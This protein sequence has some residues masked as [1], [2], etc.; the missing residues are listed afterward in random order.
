MIALILCI[1]FGY[2]GFHRFYLEKILSGIL[3]FLT[4]GL[5]GIGWLWDTVML[6]MNNAKDR[7]GFPLG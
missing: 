7:N 3:Y 4:F 5:F 1:F 2:L 6:I